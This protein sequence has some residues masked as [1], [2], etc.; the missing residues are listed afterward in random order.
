MLIG[1]AIAGALPRLRAE[2][3]SLLTDTVAL[4]RGGAVTVDD[5]GT[6]TV[7]RVVV[8]TGPAL[9]KD[10]KSES[11]RDVVLAAGQVA[12]SLAYTVKLPITCPVQVG[13][14]AEVTASHDPSMVGLSWHINGVPR[15]GHAVLHRCP[16]DLVEVS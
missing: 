2:A 1:D 14:M 13:D 5:L 11:L 10:T 3:E 8:W 4:W 15:E 7:G 9:V 16:A 6:E 12:D